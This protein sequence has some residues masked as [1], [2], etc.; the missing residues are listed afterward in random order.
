MRI[1]PPEARYRPF[2]DSGL[3]F[4]FSVSDAVRVELLGKED[5]TTGLNLVYPELGARVYCSYLAVS[6]SSLS[7]V[8]A[9]SRSFVFRQ[10]R[11][12]TRW[13]EKA[14]SNPD[15]GVYGSLFVLDGG[16]A[17][18][19]Q[20]TLTDSVSNF[21]R[22]ALY[23]DCQPNADSLAP[24]VDYIRKDIVELVRTFNWRR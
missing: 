5:G 9:E 19:I 17:S 21:F 7:S 1:E 6:P 23:F 22:G 18:P 14:Y 13:A 11:P 20:F 15:V 12:E 3:P 2:V 8:E 16:S 10:L 24:A 4:G